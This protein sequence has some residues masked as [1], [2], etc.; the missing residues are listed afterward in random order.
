VLTIDNPKLCNRNTIL[1]QIYHYIIYNHILS[2]NPDFK[3]TEYIDI[4]C[5]DCKLTHVLGNAL[6]LDNKNIYGTDIES[7]GPYIKKER[8]KLPIRVKFFNEG[9]K[10]PF[11]NSMF[12]FATAF[13]VLHHVKDLS[14]MMSEINRIIKMGGY[15]MIREHDAMT[16]ADYMLI[17]IEHMMYEMVQRDND[18]APKEYY[19]KY[20]DWIEWDYIFKKYGFSFISSYYLSNS[21]YHEQTPTRAFYIIYKKVENYKK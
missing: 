18:N 17:D 14:I 19:G 7:W 15:I 3:I 13:M 5:G 12:S 9:E 4:G 8:E 20:Y 2:N 16:Y 1:T 6:G 11:K 21:I 10:L